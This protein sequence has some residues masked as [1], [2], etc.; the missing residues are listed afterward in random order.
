VAKIRSRHVAKPNQG[1]SCRQ[2]AG[3]R[4]RL[5]SPDWQRQ[6]GA[7]PFDV[8]PH[9]VAFG[10]VEVERRSLP[11]LR[12]EDRAE[13]EGPKVNRDAGF[14]CKGVDTMAAR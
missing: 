3:L 13:Q 4:E 5:R 14:A 2:N 1:D 6:I 7:R 12:L 8:A 10:G 9:V 11:T